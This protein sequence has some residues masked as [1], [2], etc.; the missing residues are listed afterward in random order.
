MPVVI[1]LVDTP[2][3]EKLLIRCRLTDQ[4]QVQRIPGANWSDA[5][6]GWL[7]PPS[8][9][10]CLVARHLFGEALEAGARLAEASQ[11]W[12]SLA[13]WRSYLAGLLERPP[14]GASDWLPWDL[15]PAG[16]YGFQAVDAMWMNLA[17]G[18][19]L[20]NEPG[21]GKTISAINELIVLEKQGINCKPALVVC[22]S[23]V[24]SVWAAEFAK[25]A[26]EWDVKIVS[27]GAVKRKKILEGGADAFVMSW[28]T[29]RTH[30]R[31]A[32]YGNV[33]FKRCPE[34]DGEW[35]PAPPG[36]PREPMFTASKC[37]A[38]PKELNS[39]ALQ[40]VILD[41]AHRLM[42][43][44]S[45]Q[46]RAAWHVAWQA[47]RRIALTGTPAEDTIS[48]LWPILHAIAPLAFPVRGKFVELF[49]IEEH[50][51]WGGFETL[52]LNPVTRDLYYQVTQPYIRRVQKKLVLPQL[53]DKVF[54]Y[55]YPEMSPGQRKIYVQMRDEM[56]A[57]LDE[58]V[59]A[60]NPLTQAQRLSMFASATP[61]VNLIQCPACKQ[62]PGWMANADWVTEMPAEAYWVACEKCSGTA[63]VQEIDLIMP[64][65]KVDDLVEF[66]EDEGRE[67]PLV[68][69]SESKRLLALTSLKLRAEKIRHV[70]LSGNISE[71]ERTTIVRQFQ[72][73]AVPVILLTPQT[74]GEGI[75]LTRSDTIF[76]M[77][78]SYSS[79]VNLQVQ[80]RVHRIGSE[81]HDSIRVITQV[82]PD[83]IDE[84]KEE[85]LAGKA[86]RIDEI[87]RD[88][89]R[90][91]WLLKGK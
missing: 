8:H 88:S 12:G 48:D 46:T 28:Q 7:V 89:E 49:A 26:P 6:D 85:I 76:I 91:R 79:R 52:G 70:S 68:V 60:P 63:Q 41:E 13:A 24:K 90:L 19:L 59:V 67:R 74:G 39:I 71:D 22:P 64:S 33:R 20:T 77:M 66:I 54:E 1:D 21:T 75:T 84:R 69:A 9:G 30:T 32:P 82:V 34:H 73:G 78:P 40:M 58:I 50:K 11:S 37:E 25:W 15:A 4:S 65:C 47:P 62:A 53:P 18:S 86:G 43:P 72:E 10:A 35:K 5:F 51:F 56:L 3:G 38:H 16:L 29:L 2:K 57:R 27:G 14:P 23:S 36:A 17:P 81:V 45:L 83:T 61:Q 87:T 55:R 42:H 44:E 80:D 31:L